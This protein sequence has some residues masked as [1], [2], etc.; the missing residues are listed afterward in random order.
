MRRGLKSG[1]RSDLRGSGDRSRRV[2]GKLGLGSE[3][4]STTKTNLAHDLL[5][6]FSGCY[7]LLF[8]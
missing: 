4:S 7:T 1:V 6:E 3:S 2:S 5:G 8:S